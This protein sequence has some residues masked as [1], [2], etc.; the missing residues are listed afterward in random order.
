MNPA[1][2]SHTCRR[3]FFKKITTAAA[4]TLLA[5]R[6]LFAKEN[7]SPGAVAADDLTP[8]PNL[9]PKGEVARRQFGKHADVIVSAIAVGGHTF[10]TAKTSGEAINIV[11]EA[12]DSGLNFLDNAWEYHDGKSEELMGQA[13]RDGYRDKAFLM[14]KV[15]THGRGK[16]VG[17]RMLEESLKRLGTDH[18]DLWQIHEVVYDDDPDLIFKTGGVIEALEEAKQQGKVRFIGFTG[19]K[20]P[21]IHLKMLAH[22]Y[23]FDSVQMPLSGFDSEFR[24]FEKNVLPEARKQGLAVLGM[25][26]LNGTAQA[27]KDGKIK[28]EEAIRY[29]MSLPVTTTVSGM[30]SL[31]ILHKN[32][33]IARHFTP[34]SRAEML[35]YRATCHTYAMDGRYELY[36]TSMHFDG[37][38]G[39]EQHGFPPPA[40]L[41]G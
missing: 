13:L 1:D 41:P 5:G 37:P 40:K 16:D 21:A 6:P 35:A 24:S 9:A 10:A 38:P 12:L 20:D 23:P 11:R 26:S 14:T 7:E 3:T 28:P 39:R 18:L 2:P 17:M 34:M 22:K 27:V 4:A 33:A 31:D 15:C 32:L 30:D 36:K 19:H 25:K 8:S 29:A